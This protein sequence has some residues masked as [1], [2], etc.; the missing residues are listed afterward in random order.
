MIRFDRVSFRYNEKQETSFE[1]RE[2]SF[3]CAGNKIY[4][5]IGGNGSG[6]STYARLIS[7]LLTPDSGKIEVCG[8]NTASEDAEIHKNVGIIFQNPENQIVGTTVEEDIAFGLENLSVPAEEMPE[9]INRIAAELG[10][11]NMLQKPVHHLSGG[12][13]QLLCVASVLV[14][15]PDWLIFDEP[16][17]HLDP[18]SRRKFWGILKHLKASKEVGIIVISQISDDFDYFDEI[19]VFSQ[20]DIIFSGSPTELKQQVKLKEIVHFPEKWKYE[21]L[22]N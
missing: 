8:T 20:G 1:I 15:Q 12:Q 17:S 7:G 19:K 4:G 6:K 13:Q 10:I 16:T 2:V 11:E 14:M 5:F 18:W 9:K 3:S 22:Q 21:E